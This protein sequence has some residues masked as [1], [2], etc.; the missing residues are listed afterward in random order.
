MHKR[1]VRF[2]SRSPGTVYSSLFPLYRVTALKDGPVEQLTQ[3]HEINYYPLRPRES[4]FT[5]L[6]WIEWGWRRVGVGRLDGW[7]RQLKFGETKVGNEKEEEG[8]GWGGQ[9]KNKMG[10]WFPAFPLLVR[11]Q[12]LG[13]TRSTS[14]ILRGLLTKWI[15]L[16]SVTLFITKSMN[17]RIDKEMIF[18]V[19]FSLR[20]PAFFAKG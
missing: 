16:P 15:V 2:T 10:W 9:K 14:W 4:W 5:F 6:S 3:W 17:L 18:W 19:L 12:G 20:V 11:P 13:L 1:T 8:R 7:R